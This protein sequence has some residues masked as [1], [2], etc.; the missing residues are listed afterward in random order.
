MS[1]RILNGT[2]F[3]RWRP[4]ILAVSLLF[5]PLPGWSEESPSQSFSLKV[6]GG[7][8][9]VTQFTRFEKPFWQ[10][11]VPRLTGGRVTAEIHAFDQSGFAGQEMLQLMRLGVVTFGTALLA[12]VAGD[13][14]ELN[15]VDL[16]ILNP[17]IESLRRTVTLYR[18]HLTELLARRY[19]VELLA[20]YAYPAQVLFCATAFRSL[21]DMAGRRVRTSSVGQSEMM[22]AL[23]AIPIQIPFAKIVEAF[24]REEVDCAITGTRSGGEIGL[25]EVTSHISPLAI[26][27]GLSLFGANRETWNQLPPDERARLGA[28]IRQLEAEIWDAAD[29]ETAIGFACNTAAP[30]CVGGKVYHMTTVPIT[31]SDDED[32]KRLLVQ[33]VLPKWISRCGQDCVDAWNAT[34]GPELAIQ[35]GA[36]AAH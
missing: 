26:S 1:Y 14:P 2:S 34:I 20:I 16:P 11:D 23:G 36:V 28:G 8:A 24:R 3:N 21:R 29:R 35:I 12:Q 9:G 10:N 6:V 30:R 18:P 19:D 22:A 27:W 4:A 32:R 17:D 5:V 33:T 13:E 7:L 31:A 15:A 25:P